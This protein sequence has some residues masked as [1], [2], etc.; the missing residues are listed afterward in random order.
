VV[1][2]VLEDVGNFPFLS[3]AGLE[4]GD[5]TE[6]NSRLTQVESSAWNLTRLLGE[7][8]PEPASDGASTE[9]SRI[10]RALKTMRGLLAAYEPRLTQ[11][12]ERT[13]GLKSKTLGWILPAS[14]LVSFACFWIALSQVSLMC[15]AWSWCRHSGHNAH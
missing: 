3:V 1:N 12:R 5:L 15:H 2:S 6:T 11:V 10:E 9:V 13:E 7:P 14:V 8:G 4:V